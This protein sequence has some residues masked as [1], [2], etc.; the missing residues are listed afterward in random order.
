[1]PKGDWKGDDSTL[2]FKGGNTRVSEQA[3][4]LFRYSCAASQMDACV[5]GMR[6]WTRSRSSSL[7]LL[8][9]LWVVRVP[10]AVVVTRRTIR[11]L[12]QSSSRQRSISVNSISLASST[13]FFAIYGSDRKR[14]LFDFKIGKTKVQQ[15]DEWM[16]V[17]YAQLQNCQAAANINS[18]HANANCTNTNR[19]S[20]GMDAID[21]G[22]N[23]SVREEKELLDTTIMSMS[24][25]TL[26]QE[27]CGNQSLAIQF[28]PAGRYLLIPTIIG[29][30][31]IE[32]STNKCRKVIGKGD[33]ST[34]R[35]QA[36]SDTLV[37]P[38]RWMLVFGGCEGGQE[39]DPPRS[40][41]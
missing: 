7:E 27:Q 5:W 22:R 4:G 2:R 14:R 34:L 26:S 19:H 25:K 13:H 31:V 9:R 1:M 35:F 18:C 11:F 20:G 30:K 40:S 6:R 23:Q 28:D 15:Y 38:P 3:A 16:K 12:F 32:W 37:L 21:Y 17:Y 24:S 39:A 10:V 36:C 8:M 29:I 41:C 33:D